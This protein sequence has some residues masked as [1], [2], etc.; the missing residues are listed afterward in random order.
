VGQDK[1]APYIFLSC[2][3]HSRM[4]GEQL[5]ISMPPSSQIARNRTT[6][7]STSVTSVRS[8]TNRGPSCW[9]CFFNSPTCS[10]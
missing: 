2:F 9:S 5:T 6:S 4:Q 8:K 1:V 10:D 3:I 7:T